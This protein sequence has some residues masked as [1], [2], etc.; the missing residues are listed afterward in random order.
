[1]SDTLTRCQKATLADVPSIV[2][3]VRALRR[4]TEV[5]GTVTTHTQSLVFRTLPP[6]VLIEVANE[7]ERPSGMSAVLS[8]KEAVSNV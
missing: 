7:L 3:T 2:E 4:L 8:S 1:M 6:R 5:T